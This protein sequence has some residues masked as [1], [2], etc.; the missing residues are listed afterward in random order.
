MSGGK[1]RDLIRAVCLLTAPTESLSVR[2]HKS[3][4][5]LYV[6]L[7]E[8]QVVLVSA[9]L[10]QG[11]LDAGGT[12]QQL[13]ELLRTKEMDEVSYEIQVSEDLRAHVNERCAPSLSLLLDAAAE[14][15]AD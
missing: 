2:V 13:A 10:R 5:R 14:P 7:G 6:L 12:D 3:D 11:M 8:V 4:Y 15:A 1:L 9:A